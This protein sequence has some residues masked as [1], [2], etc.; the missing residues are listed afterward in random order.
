MVPVLDVMGMDTIV[1]GY[2]SK[3]NAG[4]APVVVGFYAAPTSFGILF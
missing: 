4:S 1:H 2:F 3:R